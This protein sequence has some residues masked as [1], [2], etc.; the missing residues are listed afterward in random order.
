MISTTYE[1]MIPTENLNKFYN[2]VWK[3][4][5]FEGDYTNYR[6][7]LVS[8]FG[9][10]KSFVTPKQETGHLL[11]GSLQEGY[12]IIRF[13]MYKKRSAEALHKLDETKSHLN[14]ALAKVAEAK[15]NLKQTVLYK[16]KNNQVNRHLQQL[17]AE[18]AAARKKYK[19]TYKA[20]E[21]KRVENIG[22]LVHRMVAANFCIKPSDEHVFVIH[23]DYNRLNNRLTNLQW[24]TQEM[25]TAHQ[26]K[27][28]FVIEEKKLRGGNPNG[29]VRNHKLNVTRV[30][31]IKKKLLEGKPMR[32]L[33]K[34]FKVTETQIA[35]IKKGENWKFVP[36]AN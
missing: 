26:Q 24:A 27:S 8:D 19:E 14:E 11:K 10:V 28:P 18:L 20:A 12:P 16:G 2:E 3:E 6:K 1:Y 17:M 9:R 23:K 13:K 33:A 29:V 7:L 30:M 22:V 34:Q 35:R 4:I 21:Q 32:H 25:S 31:L 15:K 5:N 36:A